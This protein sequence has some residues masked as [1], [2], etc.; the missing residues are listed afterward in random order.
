MD[1][2]IEKGE[3]GLAVSVRNVSAEKGVL[4]KLFGITVRKNPSKKELFLQ[5][6][7]KIQGDTRY[8]TVK[9]KKCLDDDFNGKILAPKAVRYLLEEIT[10]ME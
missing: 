2:V 3:N 8:K 4:I 5:A 10:N 9:Y 1:F 7:S 6:I